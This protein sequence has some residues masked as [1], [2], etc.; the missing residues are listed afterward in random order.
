MGTGRTQFSVLP[1]PES[2]NSAEFG[3]RGLVLYW[4][5]AGRRYGGVASNLRFGLA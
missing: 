1:L 5:V 3:D 2:D 4:F